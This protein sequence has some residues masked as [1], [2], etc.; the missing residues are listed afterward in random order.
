MAAPCQQLGPAIAEIHKQAILLSAAAEGFC[1]SR[2][3][4]A[5]PVVYWPNT[6]EEEEEQRTFGRR[7]V[8]VLPPSGDPSG[9]FSMGRHALSL[10]PHAHSPFKKHKKELLLRSCNSAPQQQHNNNYVYNID[11]IDIYRVSW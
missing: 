4:G 2:E 8:G 9:F 7:R 6:H 5:S 1:C 3:E 11:C 10:S